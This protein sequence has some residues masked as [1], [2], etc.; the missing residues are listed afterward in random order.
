MSGPAFAQEYPNRP[1]RLIVPFPPAGAADVISRILGEPLSRMLG[2][3]VVVDNRAGAGGRIGTEAA[4][5]AEPDG[6]SIFMGSQ[7]TNSINPELYDKLPFD[8]AKD[9]TPVAAVGGV[10]SVL[11]V[12]NSLDIQTFPQFLERARSKPGGMTYGSAG[13]GGGSHLAMALLE[14]MARIQ[15]VHV[16]YRGTAP[17]TT[18]VL[19]GQIDMLCDVIT[20]GLPHVRAGSVRALAVT[21]PQRHPALP[22]VPTM[23][24]AGVPGYEAVSYYGL[25][26]PT[27]V[28]P[29]ILA[30]LRGTVAKVLADEAMARRLGELGIEPLGLTPDA[31]AEYVARDRRRWG[32][33]I[34]GA[35]IKPT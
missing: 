24:E 10:G 34:R 1:I 28:P 17:A 20:T 8:P 13:N 3:Q 11:Y 6:Y 7:A 14:T 25:F 18:D 32:E 33:V 12:R 15:L 22:D 5:R 35:G 16:P 4:V 31:F 27:A 2:Q 21:T 26:A 9:L 19:A 29:A 30:T 23:A